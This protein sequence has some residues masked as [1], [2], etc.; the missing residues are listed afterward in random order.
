TIL[1]NSLV[2]LSQMSPPTRHEKV[3]FK[4]FSAPRYY[5]PRHLRCGASACAYFTRSQAKTSKKIACQSRLNFDH[6]K[7]FK[8]Q[9]LLQPCQYGHSGAD[10][11]AFD[12][13]IVL[14]R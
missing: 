6:Y 11:A 14:G 13:A 12:T 5:A 8:F 1:Y 7:H 4:F 2:I 9:P 3:I 10:L